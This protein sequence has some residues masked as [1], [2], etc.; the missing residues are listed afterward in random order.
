MPSKT[1]VDPESPVTRAEFRRYQ[2]LISNL[3]VVLV[4][5]VG[6]L[7]VLTVILCTA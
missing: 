3:S 1:P 6:L 5:A 7:C 4:L 2:N